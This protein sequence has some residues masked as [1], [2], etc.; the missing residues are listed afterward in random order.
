MLDGRLVKSTDAFLLRTLLDFCCGKAQCWPHTD[1]LARRM[2]LGIRSVQLSIA[3]CT[4]SG[5]IAQVAGDDRNRR[6]VITSHPDA[7]RI[8]DRDRQIIPMKAPAKTPDIPVR[9]SPERGFWEDYYRRQAERHA[10]LA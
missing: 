3:R 2:R 8:L 1:T 5:I 4:A 10:G 6:L 9:Q 7:R